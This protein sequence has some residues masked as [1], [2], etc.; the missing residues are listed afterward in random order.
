MT[1]TQLVLDSPY[2]AWQMTLLPSLQAD[3]LSTDLS[4]FVYP[5]F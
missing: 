1:L 3:T 4:L 5:T 2:T